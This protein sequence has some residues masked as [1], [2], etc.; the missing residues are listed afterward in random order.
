MEGMLGVLGQPKPTKESVAYT[1]YADNFAEDEKAKRLF[2]HPRGE[3]HR[4]IN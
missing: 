1:R 4:R 2:T 3:P